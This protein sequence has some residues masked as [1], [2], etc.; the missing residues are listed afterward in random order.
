MTSNGFKEFI[1][2]IRFEDVIREEEK[3]CRELGA[4]ARWYRARQLGLHASTA[5]TT[6]L[7]LP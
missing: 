5:V 4:S 7:Q 3:T 2:L 6:G 1:I